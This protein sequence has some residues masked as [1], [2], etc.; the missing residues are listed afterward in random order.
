MSYTPT[1]WKKGDIITATK[2]NKMEKGIEDGNAGPL[3]VQTTINAVDNSIS[4]NKSYNDCLDALNAGR[5]VVF[6]A[7]DESIYTERYLLQYLGEVTETVDEQDVT[8]YVVVTNNFEV[9]AA[10]ADTNLAYAGDG[11]GH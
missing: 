8:T 2:L 9:Y 5:P 10:D 7:S 6:Y 3:V 4:C 1:D 11:G